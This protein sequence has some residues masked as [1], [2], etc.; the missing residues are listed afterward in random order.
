MAKIMASFSLARVQR[1]G[2]R[3]VDSGKWQRAYKGALATIPLPKSGSS[4]VS[5]SDSGKRTNQS[6]KNPQ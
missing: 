5:I 2:F 6:G 1:D 3:K 4:T